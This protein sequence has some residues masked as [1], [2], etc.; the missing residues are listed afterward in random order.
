[1]F[2]LQQTSNTSQ[3]QDNQIPSCALSL[4]YLL[5]TSFKND[6]VLC[7]FDLE[8]R[9]LPTSHQRERASEC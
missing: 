9:M 5:N 8:D 4:H 1:M 2:R 7:N 3:Y 6:I